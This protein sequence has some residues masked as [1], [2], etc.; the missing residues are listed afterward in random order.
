MS[1]VVSESWLSNDLTFS[2]L[3]LKNIIT[4]RWIPHKIEPQVIIESADEK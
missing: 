2:F 3:N 4:L 1:T